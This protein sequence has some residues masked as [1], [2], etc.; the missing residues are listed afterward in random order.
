LCD[1]PFEPDAALPIGL[2]IHLT[3]TDGKQIV[4]TIN[5]VTDGSKFWS[6]QFWVPKPST[7]YYLIAIFNGA[8]EFSPAFT[9]TVLQV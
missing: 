1:S 6:T 7:G 9:Q 4:E 5:I 2:T 8:G 3:V